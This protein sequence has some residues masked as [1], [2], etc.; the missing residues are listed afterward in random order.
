MG[1]E[2]A[3]KLG[4]PNEL[5]EAREKGGPEAEKELFDTLLA[6]MYAHGRALNNTTQGELD[7]TIDPG[8]TRNWILM[9]LES[10]PAP[11]RR[12]KGKKRPSVSTW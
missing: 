12:R 2:G 9:G 4:F 10:N 6:S 8:E 5:A 1:L 7:D 11:P 3:T